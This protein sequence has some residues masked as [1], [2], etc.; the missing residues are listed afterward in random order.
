MSESNSICDIC[1]INFSRKAN[2]IRHFQSEHE[3]IKYLCSNC[4]KLFSRKENFEKHMKKCGVQQF[5]LEKEDILQQLHQQ[6]DEYLESLRVGEM[7]A[8]ILKENPD[9]REECLT[10]DQKKKLKTFEQSHT[11]F[12]NDI[13]LRPWQDEL[14]IHFENPTDREVIWVNGSE[15]KTFFQKYIL[16]VFGTRRVCMLDLVN[17]S[18]NIFQTLSKY[19]LT[20][21]DIFLFNIPRNSSPEDHP[22][23][24][25][26]AIKDGQC[27]TSKYNSK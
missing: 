21:K 19:P 14:I 13:V 20:C 4:S 17:G 6:N 11:Y 25:L 24:F 9:I 15:G 16:S 22:Y 1:E 27:I 3:N 18:K 12:M 8:T 26:E 10:C 7:Y 2:Y 5:R 23:D